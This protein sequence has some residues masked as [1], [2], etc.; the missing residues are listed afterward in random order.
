MIL[1]RFPRSPARGPFFFRSFAVFYTVVC[2]Y[3]RTLA[4]ERVSDGDSLKLINHRLCSLLGLLERE[5][6][7][8]FLLL[9]FRTLGC[10]CF[11]M[12]LVEF[13]IWVF[14]PVLVLFIVRLCLLR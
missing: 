13:S 3:A 5:L 7:V 14:L 10:T 11:V 1:S 9:V 8:F 6:C 12:F 2:N 4:S